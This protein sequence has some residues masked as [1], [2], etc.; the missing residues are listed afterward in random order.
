MT[1]IVL[2]HSHVWFTRKW[3]LG[4]VD[5]ELGPENERCINLLKSSYLDPPSRLSYNL[6]TDPLYIT[7]KNGYTWSYIDYFIRLIFQDKKNGVFVEAGALDGEFLSNTLRLEMEQNWTGLIIE[8]DPSS[9][10]E[11][12][13]KNRKSWSSNSCISN[14]NYSK[15][16]TFLSREPAIETSNK[17][18]YKGATNELGITLPPVFNSFLNKTKATAIQVYCFPFYT[19]LL[20]LNMTNIDLVSLDLQGSEME[21]LRSLP[22]QKIKVKMFIIETASEKT[23]DLNLEK[24]LNKKGYQMIACDEEPNYIYILKEAFPQ[25]SFPKISECNLTFKTKN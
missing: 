3:N 1:I 25:Y 21:V 2:Y 20:A 19:Y 14:T 15:R 7:M 24:F 12:L 10:R 5:E 13:R 17:W 18:A 16:T 23:F 9:Y 22:F 4:D 8:P 11:L 6:S